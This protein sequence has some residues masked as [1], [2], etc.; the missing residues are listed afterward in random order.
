MAVLAESM[1]AR[2]K[3]RVTISLEPEA[4]EVA[5]AEVAAGNAP[6][7]SAAIEA[8][9]LERKRLEAFDELLAMFERH[10][11]DNPLTEE[12]IRKGEEELERG[13]WVEEE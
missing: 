9:L 13:S 11:R 6:N 1:M 3:E 2:M 5:R 8:M 7:L 10:H 4:L 12:E